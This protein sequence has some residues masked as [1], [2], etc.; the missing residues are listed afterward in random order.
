[1][2]ALDLY[3]QIEQY[4]GFEEQIHQLYKTIG[5]LVLSKEPKTLIDIGCG[6][7]EF[8]Y[9][10]GYNGIDATGIDLSKTQIDLGLQKD[11]TLKLKTIDVKDIDQTYDCATAIFD[12]INYIPK[13]ELTQFLTNIYNVVKKDGYFIFDINSL[14]GFEE[15]A[16]GTL[17]IDLD[18]KF[19]AIDASYENSNLS[20]QITLF[21][22]DNKCYTKDQGVI[23]Q[24]YHSNDTLQKLLKKVGFKVDKIVDFNLHSFDEPDKYIF[25][26][27][28]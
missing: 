23:T 4:L 17:N 27:K 15:I 11:N 6:Q 2:Q 21:Q 1:L 28:K 22:K 24:Y 26:V 7:G 14:F 10:M 18:D 25:V 19:I 12:V 5:H 20:T 13:E 9:I 16:T 3:G 8:C